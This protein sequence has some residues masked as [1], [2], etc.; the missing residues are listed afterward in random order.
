MK[1][2]LF[3]L[4]ILCISA[5]FAGD[6]DSLFVNDTFT[7]DLSL[8]AGWNFMSIPLMPVNTN[9][10]EMLGNCITTL[11]LRP[12]VR[13]T[14][15]SFLESSVLE[16]KYG[17]WLFTPEAKIC[18]INGTPLEDP[19]LT[20][21]AGWNMIGVPSDKTEQKIDLIPNQVEIRK[22]VRWIGNT[23]K[24]ITELQPGTAAWVFVTESTV[25]SK[26]INQSIINLQICS[27]KSDDNPC[28]VSI[29]RNHS[30]V[31]LYWEVENGIG[32]CHSFGCDAALFNRSCISEFRLYGLMHDGIVSNWK[33]WNWQN[34]RYNCTSDRRPW[35]W[36][37]THNVSLGQ[38]NFTI[39]Q[40]DCS[41][42]VDIAVIRY[43]L[44]SQDNKTFYLTQGVEYD[45]KSSEDAKAAEAAEISK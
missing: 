4:F 5:V 34:W 28:N 19:S 24:E 22:P 9:V 1:W 18:V 11:Q 37:S 30:N 38:H 7:Y 2:Q 10:T 40:R 15:S 39:Y 35:N 31:Y 44:T 25:I 20:L 8:H 21:H 43:N 23:F 41:T 12:P 42:I 14:G 6:M 16:P 36:F 45:I 29:E 17:Y 3:I 32:C 27:E 26:P 13:W 33:R